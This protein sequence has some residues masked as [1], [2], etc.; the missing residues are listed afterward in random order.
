M[1]LIGP[2]A[3][4]LA[5]IGLLVLAAACS[6]G[7]IY[8]RPSAPVP[9]VYKEFKGWKVAA[10]NDTINISAGAPCYQL[11]PTALRRFPQEVTG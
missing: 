5:C 8:R 11:L 6:V 1:R 2:I 4:A 10:P 3:R 9:T 7:P